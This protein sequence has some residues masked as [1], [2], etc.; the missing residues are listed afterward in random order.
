MK[1]VKNLKDLDD[2]NKILSEYKDLII[3]VFQIGYIREIVKDYRYKRAEK[4]QSYNVFNRT[5]HVALENFYILLLWKLFDKKRSK[6]SVYGICDAIADPNF[7]KFFN[8]EIHKIKK[9]VDILGSWRNRIICH[10]DITVHFSPKLIENNFPL[11]DEDVEKLKK[12]L[13]EFLCQLDFS[14]HHNE[15]N[16]LR[17]IYQSVLND[18]KNLCHTETE[19]ILK[20]FPI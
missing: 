19:K 13:L 15:I 5:T 7:K 17:K 1:K 3:Q 2:L 11:I 12:F 18:L 20:N 9:M 6:M 10:R 16:E 8:N 14:L 4:F